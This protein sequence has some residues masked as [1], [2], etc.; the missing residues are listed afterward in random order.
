MLTQLQVED[1]AW[2]A[3]QRLQTL[4]TGAS[5]DRFVRAVEFG[6]RL[7]HE[8]HPELLLAA[9]GEDELILSI[10]RQVVVDVD[11]DP[12][13]ALA[14]AHLVHALGVV[15]LRDHAVEQQEGLLGEERE[16]REEPA[17]AELALY[18]V[19]GRRVGEQRDGQ[20]AL[21]VRDGYVMRPEPLLDLTEAVRVEQI[22]ALDAA[23]VHEQ[24]L[25]HG[26]KLVVDEVVERGGV[27][28]HHRSLERGRRLARLLV[29]AQLDHGRLVH[30]QRLVRVVLE[31]GQAL[32]QHAR[33]LVLEA[34]ETRFVAAVVGKIAVLAVPHRADITHW[35]RSRCRFYSRFSLCFRR[36]W[37]CDVFVCACVRECVVVWYVLERLYLKIGEAL[38]FKILF[39][40][41]FVNRAFIV[42]FQVKVCVRVC[43][44]EGELKRTTKKP[45][46]EKKTQKERDGNK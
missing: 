21:L 14:Q 23:A 13:T 42:G 8:R 44:A 31:R 29:E 37:S 41:A 26:R 33:V 9:V 20:R 30:V 10:A 18:D 45:R 7:L 24:R 46:R 39:A 22:A 4:G 27:A 35:I 19:L 6:E 1:L 25:L 5:C 40:R 12:F 11:D 3:G 34:F 32:E 17:R 28:R 15:D 43:A 38:F 16:R 2:L 36:C